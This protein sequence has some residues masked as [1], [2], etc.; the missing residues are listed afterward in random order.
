MEIYKII[1]DYEK[2]SISNLGNVKNI[3]G[4]ILKIRMTREGYNRVALYNDY[5]VKNFLVHRL[6]AETFLENYEKKPQINHKDGDKLNNKVE[7]L[8]WVTRSENQIHRINILNKGTTGIKLIKDNK[9]YEFNSLAE[10]SK[11][12]NLGRGNLSRL[13]NNKLKTYNG[14]KIFR[15]EVQIAD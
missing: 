7:N 2:Y 8:E 14:F 4:K 10:C 13:N 1:K 9:I 11:K 15:K 5:G 12:L 3:H 6:V